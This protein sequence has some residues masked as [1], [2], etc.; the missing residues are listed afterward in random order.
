MSLYR[1]FYNGNFGVV[2]LTTLSAY[3]VELPWDA[4]Q[5]HIGGAA[6]NARLLSQ[7]ESDS[8]VLGTGPLT[9][10]FAPASALLVGTFRSPR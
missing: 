7:F 2:D 1:P 5:E 4:C 8:I 6:M 3:T 10:S 9:G